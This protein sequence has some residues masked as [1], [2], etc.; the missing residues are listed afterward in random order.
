MAYTLD[1]KSSAA[2]RESSTLSR[3]TFGIA[4]LAQLVEHSLCKRQVVSSNLTSGSNVPIGAIAQLDRA[5][6]F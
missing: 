1:L 5:H 3:G 6:P 4:A 2:R